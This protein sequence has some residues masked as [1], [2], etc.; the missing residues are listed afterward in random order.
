MTDC[1]SVDPR[2]RIN[3]REKCIWKLFRIFFYDAID[4]HAR[5]EES[6]ETLHQHHRRK[7]CL[8]ELETLRFVSKER[9]IS[10]LLGSIVWEM[11]RYELEVDRKNIVIRV[12]ENTPQVY[13][14][15]RMWFMLLWELAEKGIIGNAKY[16]KNRRNLVVHVCSQPILI[17]F[18]FSLVFWENFRNFSQKSPSWECE[19]HLNNSA[20]RGERRK[21]PTK[22]F[23]KFS[24]QYP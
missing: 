24:S 8:L 18:P 22:K 21:L 7:Y 20:T 6:L 3:Q 23:Q 15:C 1:R 10:Y 9:Y 17:N 11:T 5:E 19:N 2:W 13:V 12:R 4:C 16:T 14:V